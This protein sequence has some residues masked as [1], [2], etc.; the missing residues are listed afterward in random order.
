MSA[1]Y[2]RERF[3]GFG[4]PTGFHWETGTLYATLRTSPTSSRLL[5]NTPGTSRQR[6]LA[7]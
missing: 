3:P 2:R 1:N 6:T 5:Q 7:Q 4:V